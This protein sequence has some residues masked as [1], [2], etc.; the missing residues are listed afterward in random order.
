MIDY[1]SDERKEIH[2]IWKQL[3]SF[4]NLVNYFLKL[5]ANFNIYVVNLD[6]CSRDGTDRSK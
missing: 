1:S 3:G 5:L 4:N 2:S 6:K